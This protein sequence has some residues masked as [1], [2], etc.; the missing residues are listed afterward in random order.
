MVMVNLNSS[1]CYCVA[2]ARRGTYGGGSGNTRIIAVDGQT[3]KT[4]STEFVWLSST[5]PS[6]VKGCHKSTARQKV[7]KYR[8][9]LAVINRY[10]NPPHI[11][12]HPRGAP[13]PPQ[14]SAARRSIGREN[15]GSG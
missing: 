8:I 2:C 12:P 1:Y 9:R 7:K 15:A 11:Q 4:K 5:H 14:K 3:D 6:A 10:K 13:L